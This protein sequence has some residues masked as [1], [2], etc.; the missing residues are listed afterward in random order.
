M[1][2]G[3]PGKTAELVGD[4]IDALVAT[5]RMA[6][7]VSLYFE[8][9]RGFAG[10]MF[11]QLLPSEA[12]AIT[13]GDLLAVSLLDVRFSPLAVRHLLKEI[14]PVDQLDAAGPPFAVLLDPERVPTDVPLWDA[15]DH[16]LDAVADVFGHLDGLYGVGPVKASK[17]LARKRPL[18]VPIVDRVITSQL[19]VPSSR[20][21]WALLRDALNSE[22]R[23]CQIDRL[24]PADLDS[25]VISTLRLLDVAAWMRGSRSRSAKKARKDLGIS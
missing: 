18:L 10:S 19:S 22:I 23:R 17:L 7:L 20:H 8:P 21:G 13:A 24:R 15:N 1:S 4:R 12:H 2:T 16:D 3:V 25:Q 14:P 5:P 11:D 6:D 9:E